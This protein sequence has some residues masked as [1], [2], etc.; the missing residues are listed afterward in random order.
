MHQSLLGSS[1]GIEVS[2]R[3]TGGCEEGLDAGRFFLVDR[4]GGMTKSR[5]DDRGLRGA[6][7]ETNENNIQL[8]PGSKAVSSGR[9]RSKKKRRF[10]STTTSNQDHGINFLYVKYTIYC[11]SLLTETVSSELLNVSLP[12]GDMMIY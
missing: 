9:D 5:E 2:P 4:P 11:P 1:S 6:E 8:V 3:G 7:K 12:L 10:T